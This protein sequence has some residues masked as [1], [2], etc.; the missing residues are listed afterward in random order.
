MEAQRLIA[1]SMYRG[2]SCHGRPILRLSL[3]GSSD[4]TA[5]YLQKSSRLS[6]PP[7]P[8]RSIPIS[9]CLA[10]FPGHPR[11][12]SSLPSP[13]LSLTPDV[14]GAGTDSKPGRKQREG[15]RLPNWLDNESAARGTQDALKM[16][17][18]RSCCYLNEHSLP[19]NEFSLAG[20]IRNV[21]RLFSVYSYPKRCVSIVFSVI[22]IIIIITTITV[23]IETVL[24]SRVLK[25]R[26]KL[27][28]I[29]PT[30]FDS[31]QSARISS[32]IFHLRVSCY[33]V[34]SNYNALNYRFCRLC[35][36]DEN[37]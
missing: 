8:S 17:V 29:D 1:L 25:T 15:F 31:I 27:L 20:E 16:L 28:H 35:V 24:C 4:L 30:A 19:G 37:N 13:L 33:D 32:C 22:I 36:N 18:D 5:L 23:I 26:T 6:Y 3:L 21:S 11:R 10:P 9:L 14:N 12:D 2:W 34:S 7:R